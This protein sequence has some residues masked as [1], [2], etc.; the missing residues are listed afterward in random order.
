MKGTTS[1]SLATNM[2]VANVNPMDFLPFWLQLWEAQRGSVFHKMSCYVFALEKLVNNQIL[3][4][5]AQS[6]SLEYVIWHSSFWPFQRLMKHNNTN[7]NAY[8]R[9]HWPITGILIWSPRA[10]YFLPAHSG[11]LTA[12]P[13][14]SSCSFWCESLSHCCELSLTAQLLL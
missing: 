6:S 11:N 3:I 2:L 4:Y 1:R 5:N 14:N 12:Q 10:V 9:D 13:G 7:Q 8:S